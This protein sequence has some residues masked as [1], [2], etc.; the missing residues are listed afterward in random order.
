MET[1]AFSWWSIWYFRNQIIFNHEVLNNTHIIDFIKKQKVQWRNTNTEIDGKGKDGTNQKGTT[2]MTRRQTKG[3][4]WKR[5]AGGTF[6]LNFDGSRL[7]TGETSIGYIIR[8][9]NASTIALGGQK[10]Y[11]DSVIGAEAA[12]LHEGIKE[13][14]RLNIQNIEIEGDNLSIINAVKGIRKCPWEVEMIISD[15][16]MDLT[17][18]QTVHISHVFR[19][20]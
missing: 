7:D 9:S 5:P 1:L 19:E 4:Q 20:I 3:I 8:D 12:A 13:A 11:H 16:Q 17:T 18:F 10:T 6:K 2:T 14:I 15:S